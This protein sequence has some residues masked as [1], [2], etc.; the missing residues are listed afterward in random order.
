V[1]TTRE[2]R[3]TASQHFVRSRGVRPKL[4]QAHKIALK[5]IR[6]NADRSAANVLPVIKDIMRARATLRDVAERPRHPYVTRRTMAAAV[7]R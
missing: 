5:N 1:T 6:A 2:H 3:G 4:A 7:N